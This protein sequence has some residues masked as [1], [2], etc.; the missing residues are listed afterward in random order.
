MLIEQLTT[1][2]SHQPNGHPLL[3]LVTE[4]NAAVLLCIQRQANIINGTQIVHFTLTTTSHLRK[5]KAHLSS[6]AVATAAAAE[7]PPPPV[8]DDND[9]AP[10]PRLLLPVAGV[11][12]EEF[13]VADERLLSISRALLLTNRLS[14][15]VNTHSRHRFLHLY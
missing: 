1:Q 9:V 3:V 2:R 6:L 7:A 15:H 5:D 13:C 8:G 11:G 12:G 14:Y 10:L 4:G